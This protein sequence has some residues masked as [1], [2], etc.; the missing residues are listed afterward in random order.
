MRLT[1]MIVDFLTFCSVRRRTWRYCDWGQ[2]EVG[3]GM[4]GKGRRTFSLWTTFTRQYVWCNVSG[5]ARVSRS[6]CLIVSIPVL[7]SGD[8]KEE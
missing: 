4:G 3:R 2:R 1:K 7:R 6:T 5:T 8:R